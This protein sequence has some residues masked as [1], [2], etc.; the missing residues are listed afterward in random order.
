MKKKAL[1]LT[2]LVV[3]LLL[4]TLLVVNLVGY[5]SAK[6]ATDPEPETGM[7]VQGAVIYGETIIFPEPDA[8]IDIKIDTHG[9][10]LPAAKDD[11]ELAVTIDFN[12]GGATLSTFGTIKV[13]GTSTAKWPKKNW[14]L[15]FY[16]DKKRTKTLKLKIG[17][18][19]ASDKWVAKAE[20]I[21]P[22]FLRNGLSYRLWEAMVRSRS[23][24]P[25]FEVDH[26]LA[27]L[28]CIPQGAFTGAKGFPVSHPSLVTVNN[29][30][31]GI[32]LLLLGHDPLNFNIDKNNPEH[33]YMAFDARGGYTTVKDWAK[34]SGDGIGQWLEGYSPTDDAFSEEQIK[35]IDDLGALINGSQED[36][37]A[38]FDQY[39]D[40]A[41][42]IDMLLFLEAIYDWDGIGQDIEL[43]TYDLQKWFLL[44]WD[45]D[46]TFGMYWDQ[47]GLRAGSETKLLFNYTE[48]RPTQKPWYKTYRAFTAEVEARLPS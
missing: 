42:M 29:E 39:L 21:D 17:D 22:S 33:I 18:S 48:Q 26:A 19:I 46:T 9:K 4:I 27:E 28:E 15:K 34:F 30:H 44:P 14:T 32:A 31:Y 10:A 6:P 47:S 11:G 41:N 45:K 3:S 35:A 16:A 20:W 25:Q 23:G 12:A 2:G 43:V 5:G 1:I 40:R 37:E 8:I 13:Q 7:A 38:N 36:F 24:Y